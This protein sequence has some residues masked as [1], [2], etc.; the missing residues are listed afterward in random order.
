MGA[1]FVVTTSRGIHECFLIVNMR[2]ILCPT[3]RLDGV[4]GGLINAKHYT[5]FSR[6][7]TYATTLS[8]S[9]TMT[10]F[11]APEL[12][13]TEIH[14]THCIYISSSGTQ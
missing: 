9:P 2:I 4:G 3:P 12:K 7:R 13:T 6:L 8:G 14:D 10:R 1:G 5:F 11:P